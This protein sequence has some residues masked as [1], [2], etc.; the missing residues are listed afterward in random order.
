MVAAPAFFQQVVTWFMSLPACRQ[1]GLEY[2]DAG[3]GWVRLQLPYSSRI[4]GNPETGVIHGGAVTTLID[5]ACGTAVYTLLDAPE[6]V[7]T[8][9]LRIDY[10]RPAQ[11]DVAVL[12]RAEVYRVTSQ[13]MFTRA[14]AYQGD[15]EVAHGVGTFMRTPMEAKA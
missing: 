2:I 3:T 14:V 12:C 6:Q 13:V 4:V 1:L 5:T 8:L 15:V 11:P 9:D 10:L 7:A